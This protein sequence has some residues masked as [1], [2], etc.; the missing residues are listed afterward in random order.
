MQYIA[1]IGT[2]SRSHRSSINGSR[3]FDEDLAVFSHRLS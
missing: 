1:G 2:T 3:S